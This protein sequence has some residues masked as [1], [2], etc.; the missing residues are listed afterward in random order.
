MDV[1]VLRFSVGLPLAAILPWAQGDVMTPGWDNA[2]GLGLLAFV[3]G[4]LVLSLYYVGL[5]A[6]PAVRATLAGL[7]RARSG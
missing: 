3:P 2:L 7:A 1:T 6:T 5:Q 4:L